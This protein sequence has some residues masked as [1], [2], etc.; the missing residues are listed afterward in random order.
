MPCSVGPMPLRPG[1]VEWHE[2]QV[3][4]AIGAGSVI[5]ADAVAPGLLPAVAPDDG[6]ACSGVFCPQ[7]VSMTVMSAKAIAFLFMVPF[8]VLRVG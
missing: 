4:K 7:P 2:R 6:A 5:A 8:P 3:A 1:S